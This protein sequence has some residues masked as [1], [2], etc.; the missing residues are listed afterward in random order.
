MWYSNDW[1]E[2]TM[3]ETSE[4]DTEGSPERAGGKMNL[5]LLRHVMTN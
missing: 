4:G 2:D 1:C 5:K 3:Q